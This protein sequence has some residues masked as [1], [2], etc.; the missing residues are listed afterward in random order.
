MQ[1]NKKPTRRLGLIHLFFIVS[2]KKQRNQKP[3]MKKPTNVS[4]EKNGKNNKKQIFH[5]NLFFSLK[6]KKINIIKGNVLT[7]ILNGP[8]ATGNI[9][10]NIEINM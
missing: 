7:D 8:G 6:Y 4:E 1:S 2:T 3:R 9:A 10:Y 5:E